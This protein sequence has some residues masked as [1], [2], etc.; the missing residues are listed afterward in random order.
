MRHAAMLLA[1]VAIIGSLFCVCGQ[2][3][4]F[5]PPLNVLLV[6]KVKAKEAADDGTLISNSIFVGSAA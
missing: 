6:F 2:G 1:I 4:A 5:S 3:Q